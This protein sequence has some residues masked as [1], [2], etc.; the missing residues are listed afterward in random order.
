MVDILCSLIFIISVD[1]CIV[2]CLATYLISTM[3]ISE[4]SLTPAVV[5]E[6]STLSV[7]L[8]AVLRTI[9]EGWARE[10]TEKGS[11]GLGCA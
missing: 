1:L 10:G 2:T 7:L 6:I 11:F 8:I 9:V 3:Y 4:T 5:I